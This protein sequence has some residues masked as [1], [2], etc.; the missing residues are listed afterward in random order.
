MARTPTKIVLSDED[1]QVLQQRRRSP[2]T[3]QRDVLR[4]NIILAAAEGMSNQQ[5]AATVGCSLATVG[6]W[7]Q[8]FAEEGLA[9]LADEHRSGRP[10]TYDSEKVGQIVA[11]TLR[12]P[13]ERT[14][15]STRRLARVQ[16]ISHM[17]VHRIWKGLGLQPHR[18]ETFKYSTD[19]DLVPKVIDIVGLYLKPPQNA[20]VLCVDEKSQIQALDRTQPVLPLRPGQA[21]RHTHDYKRHGTAC[22]FAALNIATGRVLADCKPRHRH[23]EFLA[24]L[25]RI[26]QEY[27]DGDIHLI[28][29]N[30]STH[31]HQKVQKWLEKHPRYHLHFTPTSASWMNQ[32][33]TWFSI[34]HNQSLKRG[35]FRSVDALVESIRR[36]I[37]AWNE[38]A[39]PFV[40][41]KTAEQILEK[42]IPKK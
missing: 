36:F 11:A 3:P 15:W 5:V 21:E 39:K 29:D 28:L 1:R 18:T 24:F 30:Y 37:E 10:P 9:G 26:D 27:P 41:T 33:E 4:A 16:G 6:L 12:P 23:Q 7:R 8:R 31:K 22:L 42:A 17:T 32:V 25:K 14:H 40:W 2:T 13:T 34:L 19:P 20:L 35:V 38:G